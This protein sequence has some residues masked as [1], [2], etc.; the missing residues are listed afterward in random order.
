MNRC[1]LRLPASSTFKEHAMNEFQRA[2]L[3]K[4]PAVTLGFWI[5]KIAATTLGETA[6]DAVSMSMNLGYL[7]G[8]LIFAAIFLIAVVI[9]IKA[10][11]FHP[12]IY[13]TTIIATIV[14]GIGLVLGAAGVFGQ[15]QD[16]LNTIWE[17]KP[18]PGLG[19]KGFIRQRFLSLGM[20][21]GIGFL[22][23]V[24]LA[25]SAF[26]SASAGYFGSAIH[27]PAWVAQVLNLIAS[28]LV[29]SL[30]FALIFKVLPDVKIAWSDVWIGAVGT[31]LLFTAGKFALGLYLGRESTTSAYG[32]GSAFVLI[33]M[34]IY[35]SSLILFF[36]AEFTQVYAK[37][38]G[39]Q[40]VPTHF[41]MP[42]SERERENEGMTR[43]GKSKSRGRGGFQPASQPAG[44]YYAKKT[45]E[46][47]LGARKVNVLSPVGRIKAEPY[48]FVGLAL[49]MGLATGVLLR[50]KSLRKAVKL[51]SSVQHLIK[52]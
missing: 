2:A 1:L 11:Q 14:S 32:A 50:F 47:E 8:T 18:K 29:I 40:V 25:L 38:N 36:G 3:S 17:V 52:K 37:M 31:A 28:F 42:V 23:L 35:Y 26:I 24:S 22:L 21:L 48:S 39:S 19:I 9:Q 45:P 34:Y 7:V 41:A 5:I 33:L 30:L 51:I 6:G 27:M 4:V 46:E 15:L 10:K 13:W 44:V 16:A 20:V 49:S 43:E 12:A